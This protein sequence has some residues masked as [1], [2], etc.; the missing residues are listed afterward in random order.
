MVLGTT[1]DTDRG[2]GRE[3]THPEGE[4]EGEAEGE[5]NLTLRER[6]RQ[7]E[8]INSPRREREREGGVG[9]D[10]RCGGTWHGDVA[11]GVVERMEAQQDGDG[12][13]VPRHRKDRCE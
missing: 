3:E 9:T 2:R 10:R 11:T 6:E 7:R 5:K 8:R 13:C 4:G 1:E 12:C